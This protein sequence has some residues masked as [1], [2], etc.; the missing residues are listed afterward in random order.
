MNP[1]TQKFAG[2]VIR[3]VLLIVLAK[4]GDWSEADIDS[5][6]SALMAL[7]VV[8]WGLYEKWSSQRT[9]NTTLAVMNELT[10]PGVPA[11]KHRDIEAV[12]RKGDAAPA[13]TPKDKAPVLDG[14]GEG[15]EQLKQ[16]TARF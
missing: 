9:S 6:V 7:A 11:I 15:M 12:I 2:T 5:L 10:G 4:Y 14:P 16:A 8:A 3:S 13:A 1:L